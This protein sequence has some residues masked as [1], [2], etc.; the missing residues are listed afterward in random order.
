M[1]GDIHRRLLPRRCFKRLSSEGPYGFVLGV[2]AHNTQTGRPA[3]EI[4]VRGC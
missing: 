3:V 2:V 4:L 1:S